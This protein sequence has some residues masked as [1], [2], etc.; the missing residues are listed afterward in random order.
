MTSPKMYVVKFSYDIALRLA[1]GT[2]STIYH[3]N[4]IPITV[5]GSSNP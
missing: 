5:N 4:A 1:I 2:I 3:Y